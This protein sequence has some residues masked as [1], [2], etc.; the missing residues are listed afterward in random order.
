MEVNGGQNEATSQDSDGTEVVASLAVEA[1]VDVSGD[2]DSH[3]HRQSLAHLYEAPGAGEV[4]CS[5]LLEDKHL[6]GVLV[7]CQEQAV[8]PDKHQVAAVAGTG[9]LT[10]A[11][12]NQLEWSDFVKINHLPI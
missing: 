1:G 9:N 12:D 6:E 8:H 3:Q 7:A 5:N 10:D 4:P 2:R 11:L